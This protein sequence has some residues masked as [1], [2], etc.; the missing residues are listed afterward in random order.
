MGRGR[1]RPAAAQRGCEAARKPACEP[2][3]AGVRGQAGQL[4]RV[5]GQDLP[6]GC[7]GRASRERARAVA[8]TGGAAASR[9]GRADRDLGRGAPASIGRVPTHVRERARAEQQRAQP[10]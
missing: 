3:H 4:D 7:A 9:T 8:A 5:L 1:G 6:A 2:A 10:R